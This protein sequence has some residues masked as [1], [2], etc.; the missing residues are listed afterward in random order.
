MS[1]LEELTEYCN[2]RIT[3]KR[4]ACKKEIYA[5]QRFLRDVE[6]QNTGKFP[7]E[8]LED[9]AQKIVD[10]F[11]LL[12]HSKGVLE[13]QP[14]I[15]NTWQKLCL[16]NIYGWYHIKT[17]YRRF[18]KAFI[19]VARKNTKSQMMAGVALYEISA[20]GVNASEGFCLGTK[21]KQS[22]IVFKEANLMLKNS[23]LKCK[24]KISRDSIQHVRSDSE[25][26]PV[27]KEEGKDGDGSN[28]QF[29]CIDEYHQHPTD[30]MYSVMV[31]GMKARPEP[32]LMI[33]TTAGKDLSYPCF[34][35]E[36][37]YC[38]NII[39]PYID[40]D[41]ETYFVL[42]CELDEKDE[43]SNEENWKKA[44]PVV[45]T[46]DV[47]ITSMREDYKIAK[48]IPE[49][50]PDFKTK[51][52]NIWLQQKANGYM[53]MSKWSKC[54]ISKENPFPDVTGLKVIGGLDLSAVIDLT[55][56]SFEVEL[57][58]GR[59]A[60]MS[61]SFLAEDTLTQKI[62]TDKVPYGLWVEQ[63]WITKT[64]GAVVDY[65]YILKYMEDIYA[66]YKW[67]KGEVCFDRALAC[68]L[69]QE[70]E[71][72]GFIP[73][74]VPQGMLSLGEP[75]KNFRALA[76]SG[77][78][79]HEKNPVL[80]WAI[81][82]AVTKTDPNENIMLDKSKS[83]ERIDPIASLINAHFRGIITSI[84]HEDVFYSPNI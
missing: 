53:D 41:N 66:K 81:G 12:R 9:E 28:P 64:P 11:A 77:K 20:F 59:K 63:G 76:Y 46:Y 48:D 15:L 40:M 1:I 24:F 26:V 61:H 56:V 44:N 6:N 42:I 52:L 35:Q 83:T 4:I 58:D 37:K 27:S 29:A 57:P 80:T 17:G 8:W 13:K 25:L 71:K 30:E 67:T 36:Y 19:E 7:Y 79:I 23:P 65:A 70:L 16:C 22:R 82:N 60:V 31:T 18:R 43:I 73:I 10:W 78:V 45:M 72:K 62:Q 3:G 39:D 5:C 2:D 38:S 21:M 84:V 34:T 55:S 54:S 32:L 14:I 47:G 75:T 51:N 69:V 74:D 49:K 33:I 68:W 50:M